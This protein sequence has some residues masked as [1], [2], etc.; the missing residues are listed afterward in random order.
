MLPAGRLQSPLFQSS[1][2][3]GGFGQ[4]GSELFGGRQRPQA[5][6][7]PFPDVTSPMFDEQSYPRMTQDELEALRNNFMERA[8]E[9]IPPQFQQYMPFGGMF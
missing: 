7:M 6:P 3:V 5:Q 9:K 4:Y 1:P 8:R 2:L